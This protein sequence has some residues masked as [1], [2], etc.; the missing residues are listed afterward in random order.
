MEH[1]FPNI[2]TAFEILSYFILT[3]VLRGRSNWIATKNNA[4]P[5][6]GSKSNK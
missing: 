2:Q 5:N 4:C 3:L 6:F 1:K